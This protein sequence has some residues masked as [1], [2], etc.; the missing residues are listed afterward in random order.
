[1]SRRWLLHLLATV[2]CFCGDRLLAQPADSIRLVPHSFD[3]HDEITLL[4]GYHQGRH[5]F[6]ELGIGRSVYGMVH[7][8][9]GASVYAGA[10]VR[11][12]RPELLGVKLGCYLTGGSAFGVQ[13]IHYMD[14]GRTMQVLRP[15]IGIGFFK[16][17]ITYAYNLRLTGPR[18]D[19]VNTHMLSIGYAWRI[20]RLK[21]DVIE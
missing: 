7:H 4:T 2:L 1:M 9:F 17:R 18:I 8:P 3:A 14:G 16:A 21:R 12:D 5:G 19:G 10:E 20:K 15:E 6:A 11:I 13:V